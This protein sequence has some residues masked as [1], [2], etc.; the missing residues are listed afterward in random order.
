MGLVRM[1]YLATVDIVSLRAAQQRCNHRLCPYCPLQQGYLQV[2]ETSK[3]SVAKVKF[4]QCLTNIC[5]TKAYGGVTFKNLQV[6]WFQRVIDIAP[7]PSLSQRERETYIHWL[8]AWMGP[9]KFCTTRRREISHYY[10]QQTD[11]KRP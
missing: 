9:G 3:Y 7:R 2:F 1:P 5:L 6:Y 10:K 4:F 8:G 11:N